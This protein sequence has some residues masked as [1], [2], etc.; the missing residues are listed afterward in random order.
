M[1]IPSMT[2]R[3]NVNPPIGKLA[4]A[5]FLLFSL[6]LM[7]QEQVLPLYPGAAPGS[8]NWK[9]QERESRSN[10]WKTRVVFNVSNPTLTVFRP[11]PAKA[12]G[13]ALIICP[14]GA[15][16][17]LSIDSEGFNVARFMAARGVTCFV[18]KYRLIECHTD[19]P[20]VEVKA[21]WNR[22]EHLAA[23][24]I[25]LE[26]ADGRT[27]VDLVRRHAAEYG[28]RPDRI[29]IIGFS[30]GGTVATSVAH[31]YSR[32][33]RPDFVAAIYPNYDW[34]IKRHGVP[35]DAP[36]IFIAAATDDSIVP[37]RQSLDLYH[38]W[39]AAKK[40]AELHLYAKGGHGFGTT[41]RG[42]PSDHWLDRFADWLE[43]QGLLK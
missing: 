26:A 42:L 13:A 41:R 2:N 40:P 23:P 12:S 34:A 32:E 9:Q 4:F 29:G 8:E 10:L 25:K 18:L 33:S 1:E 37:V 31:T 39:I 17:A 3:R 11:D 28:I 36:P 20:T 21:C 22:L 7:A 6:A 27:A 30:A 5:L 15:F 43:M 38:A 14:G 24:V 19:D 16:V 35:K